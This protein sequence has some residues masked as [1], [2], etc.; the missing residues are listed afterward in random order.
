MKPKINHS[1]DVEFIE[2]S[3][4]F[5]FN[6]KNSIVSF[7]DY[8]HK[9]IPKLEEIARELFIN[10]PTRQAYIAVSEGI[11]KNNNC[12]IGYQFQIDDNTL[13]ATVFQRSQCSIYGKP[14]DIELINYVISLLYNAT[15]LKLFKDEYKTNI[16]FIIGNYH[17]RTNIN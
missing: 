5:I 1:Y 7:E 6:R 13:Y 9:I 17:S 4:P 11:N 15:I 16:T 8:E 3:E 12:L 14:Y 10:K 2:S